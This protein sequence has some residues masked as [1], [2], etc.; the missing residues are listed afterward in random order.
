MAASSFPDVNFWLALIWDGHAHAESAR[1]W[2]ESHPSERL[3][4]CRLTQLSLLRLLTTKAIMG[5]DVLSM[6][7][8]WLIYQNCLADS[9]ISFASEP[10]GLDQHLALFAQGRVSSPKVWADAYLAAFAALGGY[11]IVTFDRAFRRWPVELVLLS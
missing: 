6:T 11:R 3:L 4:F 2:R 8:A 1:F 9:F 7:E 10:D 5:N